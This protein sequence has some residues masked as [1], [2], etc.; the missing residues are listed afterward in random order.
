MDLVATCD[1]K[2][3]LHIHSYLSVHKDGKK[4]NGNTI[5]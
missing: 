5:T 4:L 2:T 1:L 3:D